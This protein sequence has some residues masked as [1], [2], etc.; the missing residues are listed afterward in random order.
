VL[1]IFAYC[2]P[3]V[4]SG[5]PNLEVVRI[6]DLLG[7]RVIAVTNSTQAR[8]DVVVLLLIKMHIGLWSLCMD[9]TG[10]L[11]AQGQKLL[12]TG[13]QDIAEKKAFLQFRGYMR[14]S[15]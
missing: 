6:E 9:I 3:R 4:A 13:M 14:W 1:N 11:K 15:A 5:S 12:P 2:T 8:D 7:G 10:L